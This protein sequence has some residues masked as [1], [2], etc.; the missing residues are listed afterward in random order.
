MSPL[1]VNLHCLELIAGLF[2]GIKV[3]GWAQNCYRTYRNNK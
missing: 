2:A 3:G 1:E